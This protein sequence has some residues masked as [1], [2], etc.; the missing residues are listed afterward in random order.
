MLFTPFYYGE[1]RARSTIFQM[2]TA[3]ISELTLFVDQQPAAAA[4]SWVK[5]VSAFLASSLFPPRTIGVGVLPFAG[6]SWRTCDQH[7]DQPGCQKR[8]TEWQESERRGCR[9]WISVRDGKHSSSL[10]ETCF[11]PLGL[12]ECQADEIWKVSKRFSFSIFDM[13]SLLVCTFIEIETIEFQSSRISRCSVIFSGY[14]CCLK[15]VLSVMS[16]RLTVD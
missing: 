3:V 9:W 8:P 6:A 5:P 15:L 7:L 16:S 10:F 12:G 1:H 14:S 11:D 4:S 2:S 13:Y